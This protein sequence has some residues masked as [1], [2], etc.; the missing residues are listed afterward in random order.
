MA[1]ADSIPPSLEFGGGE[2]VEQAEHETSQT[3]HVHYGSIQMLSL[4]CSGRLTC[5]LARNAC[6]LYERPAK[7]NTTKPGLMKEGIGFGSSLY[8]FT[9]FGVPCSDFC[10]LAWLKPWG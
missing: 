10:L 2:E 3:H 6:I 5:S 4:L 7:C 1:A 9:W 8:Q